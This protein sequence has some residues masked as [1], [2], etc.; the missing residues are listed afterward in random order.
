MPKRINVKG[1]NMASTSKKLSAAAIGGPLGVVVVWGIAAFSG[2][3]IPAEIGAAF[4]AVLTF[5]ASVAIP[6]DLED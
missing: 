1:N 4:G 6:D 5:I 2:L 3:V